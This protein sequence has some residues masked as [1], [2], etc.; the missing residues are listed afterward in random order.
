MT[1]SFKA[2]T[3]GA[4]LLG[5]VVLLSAHAQFFGGGGGRRTY[6]IRNAQTIKEQEEMEKAVAPGYKEDVFTFA[7]LRFGDS[8]GF[9]FG[10][11][12]TGTTIRQTPT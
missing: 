1:T 10:R 8:Q 3:A 5:A 11:G 7:R 9:G 12:R 4:V 6:Q 2:I